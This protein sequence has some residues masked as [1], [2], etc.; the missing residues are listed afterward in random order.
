MLKFGIYAATSPLYIVSFVLH[1]LVLVL[2][3]ADGSTVCFSRA[4]GRVRIGHPAWRQFSIR[5]VR[6]VS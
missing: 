6:V 5:D 1:G 2:P 3:V 4:S